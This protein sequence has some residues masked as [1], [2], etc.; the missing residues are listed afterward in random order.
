M[1]AKVFAKLQNFI[2]GFSAFAAQCPEGLGAQYNIVENCEIFGEGK[3]LVH[4][5]DACFES[6]LG[7]ACRKRL[8]EDFDCPLIGHIVAEENIH[9]GGFARTVFAEKATYF[10]APQVQ[11][12]VIICDKG[13]ETFGDVGKPESDRLLSG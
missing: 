1:Q 10:S 8:A 2:T 5:A 13:A 4:H 11:G 12:D 3:M 9:Q 7:S 6:S